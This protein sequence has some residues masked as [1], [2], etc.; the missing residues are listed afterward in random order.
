M[1]VASSFYENFE[2]NIYQQ[3]RIHFVF[4][5][6]HISFSVKQIGVLL[7]KEFDEFNLNLGANVK[8]QC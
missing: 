7:S 8:S 2:A 6:K 3:M 5:S 1:V 4:F